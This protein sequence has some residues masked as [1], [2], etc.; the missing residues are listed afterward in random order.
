MEA[1][2]L[3]GKEAAFMEPIRQSDRYDERV[4]KGLKGLDGEELCSDEWMHAEGVVLYRGKVYVL[5]NPQLCH[6]LVYVHHS[7]IVTRHPGHW[8]M[9]ELVSWNYWWP[10]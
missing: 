9:L 7:T 10:G 1:V 2:T 8:K 4:V 3:E 6:N 5:D